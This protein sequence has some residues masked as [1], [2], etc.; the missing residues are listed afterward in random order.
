LDTNAI[1]DIID[2]NVKFDARLALVTAS[3][4]IRTCT[5]VVGEVLYGVEN[6]PLGRRRIELAA[7]VNK[8]F[9][10]VVSEAIPNSAAEHFARLK[11]EGRA[12]GAVID[13][14]DLWIAATTLALN[15]VLSTRDKD[16]SRIKGLAVEDWTA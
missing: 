2:G 10:H 3:D 6:T 1:R 15:A 7:K 9:A 5:I 4:E 16:F 14:N 11:A 12:A 13:H 8:V